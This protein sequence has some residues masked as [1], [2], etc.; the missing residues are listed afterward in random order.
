MQALIPEWPEALDGIGSISTLR[1]GGVSSRP[2]DVRNGGGGLNL[3]ALVGDRPQDVQHNR[4]LLRALL[5]AEPVWLNQVLGSRVFAA[6]AAARQPETPL[7]DAS[8]TDW[9]S[10]ENNKQ[11]ADCLPVL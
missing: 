2:Y 8:V 4:L 1:G 7:A 6:A 9:P 5:P 10:K 3:G 11:T